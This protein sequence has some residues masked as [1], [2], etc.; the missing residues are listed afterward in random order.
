MRSVLAGSLFAAFLS[1]ACGTTREAATNA[2]ASSA[3]LDQVQSDIRARA[4]AFSAAVVKASE[5]GWA[6]SDVDALASFYTEQ[7]IVFPPR[8]EPLRGRAAVRT[9]W[10]RSTDRRILA[11]VIHPERIDV[12]STLVS[13]HG[14][15]DLTWRNGDAPAQTG[16]STYV[17]VWKHDTDGVWRK[18]IDSW[19]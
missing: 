5:S 11:H 14:R 18:H 2:P 1:G 19:W 3:S 7:T 9:Y 13:E 4:R 16:S 8:G 10:T 12:S 6:R 15:F 17:S